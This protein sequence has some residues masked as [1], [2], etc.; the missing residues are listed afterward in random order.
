VGQVTLGGRIGL[1]GELDLAGGVAVPKATL[2]KAVSGVPLPP[3]LDVPLGLGGTLGA[4]RVAVRAGDAVQGL[5]KGQVA[6]AKKAAQD[7]AQKA[8][9]KALEGLFDRF[10][11]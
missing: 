10:K 2:A 1:G 7:E 6:E 9:K 4:P 8:G 3:T 5:L 11:K